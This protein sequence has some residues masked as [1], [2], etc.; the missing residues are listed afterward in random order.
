MAGIEPGLGGGKDPQDR[1]EFRIGPFRETLDESITQQKADEAYGRGKEEYT[2]DEVEETPGQPLAPGYFYTS[3]AYSNAGISTATHVADNIIFPI[4]FPQRCQV[5]AIAIYVADNAGSPTAN[6]EA[7]VG[8]YSDINGFPGQLLGGCN[9]N[10]G[11]SSLAIGVNEIPLGATVAIEAGRYWVYVKQAGSLGAGV[12]Y[13]RTRQF[14][15]NG[16]PLNS[17]QLATT[18]ANYIG[19]SA[20]FQSL[21]PVVSPPVLP[22]YLGEGSLGNTGSRAMDVWF[23]IA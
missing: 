2:T 20:A 9:F 17:T 6:Y 8:L 7:A 4:V 16:G 18:G 5:S 23:K 12:A 1:N 10:Y 14:L 15:A 19:A 21:E 13:V 22:S 11:N 3:Q